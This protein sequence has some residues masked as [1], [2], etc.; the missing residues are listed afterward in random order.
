MKGLVIDESKLVIKTVGF[1]NLRE[2]LYI[3]RKWKVYG[4]CEVTIH[5]RRG[6]GAGN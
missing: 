3:L 5:I 6:D 2:L 4:N 1:R